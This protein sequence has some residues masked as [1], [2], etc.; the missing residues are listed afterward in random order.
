SS[1]RFEEI[2]QV[3]FA[4]DGI[5]GA[6][7]FRDPAVARFL[8]AWIGPQELETPLA[9][10]GGRL[11]SCFRICHG[12]RKREPRADGIWLRQRRVQTSRRWIRKIIVVPLPS[13]LAG[14]IRRSMTGE[15]MMSLCVEK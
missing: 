9:L 10:R 4:H 6:A 8:R 7:N 13:I 1:R 15:S 3:A 11:H 5:I 14:V 2:L 12:E